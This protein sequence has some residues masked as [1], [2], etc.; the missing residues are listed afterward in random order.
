MT[1]SA[2]RLA[3]LALCAGLIFTG[4]APAAPAS[5]GAP[6][7][8][9]AE[10]TLT[11]TL[12]DPLPEPI[13]PTEEDLAAITDVLE[14]RFRVDWDRPGRYLTARLDSV[15]VI[16]PKEWAG[17]QIPLTDNTPW[18]DGRSC[19]DCITDPGGCLLMVRTTT[20][21]TPEA[22]LCAPQ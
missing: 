12:P 20:E 21:Y 13:Q 18:L 9:A 3:A 8:S 1:R 6:A 2:F 15:Q 4:C 5:S 10:S 14:T 11:V 19:L 22:I 17:L 16:P 7:G